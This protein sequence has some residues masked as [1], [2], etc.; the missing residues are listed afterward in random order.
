MVIGD[1]SI[2]PFFRN[3][4][5]KATN[6][7]VKL[8]AVCMPQ[9]RLDKIELDLVA[10]VIFDITKMTK[11]VEEIYLLKQFHISTYPFL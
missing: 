2:V 7:D 11:H 9:I 10:R 1:E 6:K 3:T 5:R 8:K 4:I